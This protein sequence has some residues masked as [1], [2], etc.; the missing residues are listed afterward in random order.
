MP[1]KRL[2]K[3]DL[4]PVCVSDFPAV[5]TTQPLQVNYAITLKKLTSSAFPPQTSDAI[6]AADEEDIRCAHRLAEIRAQMRILD[7]EKTALETRFKV[8]IAGNA[9]MRGVATFRANPPREVTDWECIARKL[10]APVDMI[11]SHTEIKTPVR[12]FRFSFKGVQ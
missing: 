4:K 2:N 3:A 12:V 6:I 5:E 9:G 7:I 1:R 11:L 10:N 8:R